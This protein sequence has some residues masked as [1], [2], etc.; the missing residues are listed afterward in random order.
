MNKLGVSLILIFLCLVCFYF[1]V[2]KPEK[3]VEEDIYDSIQ[4]SGVLRVGV[5]TDS[6][7]FAFYNEKGELQ[8]YDIDLSR[9]IAEHLLGSGENVKFIPVTPSSRL[10]KIS[11]GEVDIV[12]ATMTITPQRE[13]IIEF[14]NPYDV[15]GQAILV[16]NSSKI[17]S[18]SDLSGLN[19]GVI[20]G[21]T[22]EKNMNNLVPSA[23]ILGFK[24]YHGA[25][26]ALKS[27]RIE[28]ITSD[29]TILSRFALED[30][31][32]TLLPK[33]YSREPYGIGFKKGKG[34]DK[35]KN[36]L[37]DAIYDLKQKNV[38]QSIHRRWLGD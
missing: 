16:R 14:S 27:G 31:Q 10:L 34:A 25:Y 33:R 1:L 36:S 37:N 26:K 29:D 17:S 2:L 21:T 18:M 6:R 23:N 30:N 32:V 19:V 11:T 4:K 7:S 35:L 9:R 3:Y 13:E 5:N 15:A 24:S 38:I 22:A 12:I 20:W 8:G 28:A